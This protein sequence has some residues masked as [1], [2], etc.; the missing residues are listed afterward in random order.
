M[1]LDE[2]LAEVEGGIM[3]PA[4]VSRWAATERT[5]SARQ[6]A[7]LRQLPA[8]S[9]DDAGEADSARLVKFWDI[10]EGLFSVGARRCL[11]P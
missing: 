5:R 9:P 7:P 8:G 6:W 1:R 4:I 3:T 10:E 2:Q 11:T